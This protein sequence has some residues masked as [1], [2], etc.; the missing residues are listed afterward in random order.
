MV[1]G[2]VYHRYA[3]EHGHVRRRGRREGRARPRGQ[4]GKKQKRTSLTKTAG[5]YREEMVGEGQ[6][7]PVSGLE[8]IRVGGGVC[9]PGASWNR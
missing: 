9:Q 6:P 1:E 4:K 3:G 5:L 8:G 2:K 7:N